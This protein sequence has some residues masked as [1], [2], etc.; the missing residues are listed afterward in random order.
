V[1]LHS[2]IEENVYLLDV[3]PVLSLAQVSTNLPKGYSSEYVIG[4][5]L[6]ILPVT[7]IDK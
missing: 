6:G 5:F 3:R 2:A 4:V 1:R 7:R